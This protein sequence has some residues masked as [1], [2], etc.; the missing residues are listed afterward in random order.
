M[1]RI[2]T[3][4][5]LTAVILCLSLLAGCD[6]ENSPQPPEE[7]KMINQEVGTMI[8][9]DQSAIHLWEAGKTKPRKAHLA[10]LAKLYK[11]S[12]KELMEDA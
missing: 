4:I 6:Q 8:G 9:V 11:C 7:P 2:K 1:T 12:E 10:E 3:L 5:L